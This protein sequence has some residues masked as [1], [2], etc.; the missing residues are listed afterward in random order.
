[1]NV[2]VDLGGWLATALPLL[3]DFLLTQRG[4][5][6]KTRTIHGV[7]VDD[8]VWLASSAGPCALVLAGVRYADG[9][10]DR[11]AMLLAVVDEHAEPWR[12]LE[13]RRRCTAAFT[14][15]TG[16][17]AL[18]RDLVALGVT[19]TSDRPSRPTMGLSSLI[20]KGSPRGR[21][22]NVV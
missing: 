17:D 3:P 2:R 20:S 4:V 7:D 6:G 22:P 5:G 21:S 12:R 11:Y 16:R 8:A 14:G 10:R 13:L 18:L 15:W 19:I 9:A 1:V